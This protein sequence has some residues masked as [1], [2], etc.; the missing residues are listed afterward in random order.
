MEPNRALSAFGHF[1][2]WNHEFVKLRVLIDLV[3]RDIF[4]WKLV[5]SLVLIKIDFAEIEMLRI[6]FLGL[7]EKENLSWIALKQ[8]LFPMSL[9]TDV[10]K[11]V[12]RGAHKRSIALENV[13]CV[14][15]VIPEGYD[16]VWAAFD[17]MLLVSI[18]GQNFASF[19]L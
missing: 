9:F 3:F 10:R 13:W 1:F 17:L 11:S 8:V 7:T 15:L 5:T 2:I 12:Y 18:L 19:G 4:V 16:R 14:V 6:S